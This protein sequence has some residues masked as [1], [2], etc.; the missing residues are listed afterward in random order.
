MFHNK[1]IENFCL[2]FLCI[3]EIFLSTLYI[4]KFFNPNFERLV[5]MISGG[6]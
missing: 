5:W 3:I 2:N 1:E 4:L 6:S